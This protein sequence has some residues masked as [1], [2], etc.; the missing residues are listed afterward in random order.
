[1]SY[2]LAGTHRSIGDR[3]EG[4]DY[5]T[6][7]EVQRCSAVPVHLY[8]LVPTSSPRMYFPVGKR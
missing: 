7:G 3:R 2:A 6:V 1:M 4:S 8:E 5:S